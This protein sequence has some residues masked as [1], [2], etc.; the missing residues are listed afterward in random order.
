[1]YFVLPDIKDLPTGGNLYN[2][3]LMAALSEMGR[4]ARPIGWDRFVMQSQTD[5]PCFYWVDS[6]FLDDCQS[7]PDGIALHRNVGMILHYLPS[8]LL[9][10]EAQK[11]ALARESQVLAR[12]NR[13]M[14]TSPFTQEYLR[15][16]PADLPP[17]QVVLPASELRVQPQA[18]AFPVRALMVANLLPNKGLLPFL[19]TLAEEAVLPDFH[20]E[21]VGSHELDK[22]Y[23]TACQAVLAAH[24]L[25]TERIHLVGEKRGD[26]LADAFAAANLYL[27]VSE[28]ESFGMAIQ[29]ARQAGLPILALDR[30]H[31]RSQVRMGYGQVYVKLSALQRQFL[32]LC[33]APTEMRLMYHRA[34]EIAPEAW[35][36]QDAA[37]VF[38]AFQPNPVPWT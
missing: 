19:E 33:T 38:L 2:A 17:V 11:E 3:R 18:K 6:L 36:W 21:V 7:L 27:S 31:I 8:M 16:S 9:D 20:L 12:F 25:L 13:L 10:G 32:T 29:E 35:C 24:P 15:Q 14:L 30:G 4:P 5:D 23:A 28:M 34:Q 1:M 22:E 37:E 26:E